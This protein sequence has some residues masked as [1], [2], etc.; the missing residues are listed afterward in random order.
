MKLSAQMVGRL[1]ELAV[2]R[3][4]LERGWIVGNFNATTANMAAYDL[5]A[6]K[7]KQRI[8]IRVKTTSGNMIQ[9]SAK[10]DGTLFVGLQKGDNGDFC[11]IVLAKDMEIKSIY[12]LPT[13]VVDETLRVSNKEWHAHPK[14]DGSPRKVT[15]H[16][17]LDFTG[18]KTVTAPHRGLQKTWASYK[19]A[20]HILE[21]P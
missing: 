14:K 1:G 12:I 16:R 4:L 3:A 10:K 11:A 6:V 8:C 17:A 5:F 13:A 19:G 15:S 20:W 9:Y 2:E 7:G 21:A 18:E